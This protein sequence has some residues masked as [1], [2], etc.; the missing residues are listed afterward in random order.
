MS[1]CIGKCFFSPV[2]GMCGTWRGG[3]DDGGEVREDRY[4]LPTNVLCSTSL[5]TSIGR[6]QNSTYLR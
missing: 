6:V 2:G 5:A 4:V 1:Y 3:G